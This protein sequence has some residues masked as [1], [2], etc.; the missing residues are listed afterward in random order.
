MGALP[1]LSVLSLC[2]QGKAVVQYPEGAHTES[3]NLYTLTVAPPGERK[4]GVFKAVM[5]PVNEYQ[6]QENQRRKYMIQEYQT[7]KKFLES[8]RETALK[9]TKANLEV[10]NKLSYEIEDL[11]PVYPLMLNITDVTPEA[12]AWEMLKN[13]GKMG[14]L[15]D[16]GGVFD[17]I[18]GLYSGG[19]SNI[20][21]F[22][23]SYDGSPCTV[24]R[25]TKE[26]IGLDNPLLT[27][28]LM[29]QPSVFH[30]VMENPKFNGKGLVQRFIFSFPETKA[31]TRSLASPEIPQRLQ[32]A[33]NELVIKLL[34]MPQSNTPPV[35][36]SNSSAAN[37][38]RDYF[39]FI[40]ERLKVG[41]QFE[42]MREYF[43]KH[44][45]KCLK[46]AGIL[47]LCSHTADEPLDELTAQQ[48]I[49]I[50]M[51]AENH[52][53]KTFSGE[54]TDS[55]EVADAKYILSKLKDC[56]SD[57][58][59]KSK[60]LRMCRMLKADEFEAP[61][62]I[63]EDMNILKRCVLESGKQ[64]GRPKECIQINPLI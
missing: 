44:F 37:I 32:N 52:A 11:K 59:P 14:I 16:E 48:A 50:A 23:K 5:K 64:G 15:D 35:I 55:Q 8:Q 19:T 30:S 49:G 58:I 3:L 61:L 40:E 39:N 60:F 28:G 12:L 51:W 4:S 18:S 9:G 17:I 21:I 10:A 13:S 41:G 27:V 24:I 22:L 7:K 54:I 53:L 45:S 31:G 62:N 29:T 63:L 42:F 56:K 33:Y 26:N 36:R 47:H 2:V 6:Q 20:D 25:R 1:L 38:F 43:N 57:T 34:S 46:I